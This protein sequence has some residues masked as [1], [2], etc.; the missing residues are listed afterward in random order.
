MICAL[1]VFKAT[2]YYVYSCNDECSGTEAVSSYEQ[3]ITEDSEHHFNYL[4]NLLR[5][6]QGKINE[7]EI[8]MMLREAIDLEINV[9]ESNVIKDTIHPS[10]CPER[11]YVYI[12]AD[13][14]LMMLRI[15][16]RFSNKA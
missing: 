6:T 16:P 8:I 15:L 9:L 3:N 5:E 4:V 11:E 2:L 12:M 10:S 14:V 1:S 7:E 13:R